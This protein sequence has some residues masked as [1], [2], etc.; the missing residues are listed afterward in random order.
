VVGEKGIR[1]YVEGITV[2]RNFKKTTKII[3]YII[4]CSNQNPNHSSSS[5]CKIRVA[6]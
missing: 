2:Q 3:I 1:I 6:T 5:A 4:W